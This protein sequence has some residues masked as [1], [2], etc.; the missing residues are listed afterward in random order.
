VL[1]N[2]VSSPR[3]KCIDSPLSI[4][5]GQ[6]ES[7]IKHVLFQHVSWIIVSVS[8]LDMVYLLIQLDFLER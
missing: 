1:S 3:Q 5:D 2:G 4:E 7:W 8:L 6:K